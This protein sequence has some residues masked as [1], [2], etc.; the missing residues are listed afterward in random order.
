MDNSNLKIVFI[1]NVMNHHTKPIAD[2]IYKK[3]GSSFI[4]IETTKADKISEYKGGDESEFQALPYLIKNDGN[5]KFTNKVKR[6]CFDADVVLQGASSDK[7]INKRL[8][9]NKL[10]FRISEHIFKDYNFFKNEVRRWKYLIRNYKFR[11]KPLFLLAASAY[12]SN[13]FSRCKSFEGKCFKW[14]YFPEIKKSMPIEKD[15]ERIELLWVG[16]LLSWK[17]PEVIIWTANYLKKNK[18]NANITVIGEGPLLAKLKKIILEKNLSNFVLF[19]GR[20]SSFSVQNY[21]LTSDVFLFSSD[22]GEGW[23]AVLNESMANKCVVLASGSAGS[24]PFLIDDGVNGFIFDIHTPSSFMSRL[25]QIMNTSEGSLE[26]IKESAR[27]TV[28]RN[29]SPQIAV[30][31]LLA[32]S[33]HYIKNKDIYFFHEGPMSEAII[34]NESEYYK[35]VEKNMYD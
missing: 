2:E 26:Q 4:F 27:N 17:H 35:R 20:V 24:T 29:W 5:R 13:D 23:G 19:V 12:A 21:M 14:G 10:T 31:R 15:H 6:L 22:I 8:K 1:S 32:I 18:I 33:N 3:I 16:R 11:D 7:F 25:D 9:S 30:E 34:F 28:I